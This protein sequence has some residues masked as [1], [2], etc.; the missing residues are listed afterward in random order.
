MGSP[1]DTEVEQMKQKYDELL[2]DN[3]ELKS[4]VKD[5][6]GQLNDLKAKSGE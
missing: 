5:L 6:E 4:K 3:E 2:K 1:T